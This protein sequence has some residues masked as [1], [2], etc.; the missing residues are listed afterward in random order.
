MLAYS[1]SDSLGKTFE[2]NA[3]TYY[4]RSRQSLWTKGET[5][6]NRQEF[7]TARWDCDRD[8]LLFTVRQTG[9]GACH[10]GAYSCFGGKRFGFEELYATLAQRIANPSPGSYTARLA[11]EPAVLREKILEEAGEVAD[12]KDREN[13]VWELADLSYFMMVLMARNGIAPDEVRNEL[14]RRRK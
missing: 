6:G 3:A 7:L 13:L 12:Y 5:S 2:S 11:A 10:T 4:S 8:A 9:E 14:W 1:N